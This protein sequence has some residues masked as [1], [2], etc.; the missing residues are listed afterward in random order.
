MSLIRKTA[1]ALIALLVCACAA[2]PRDNRY[3]LPA[4]QTQPQQGAVGELQRRARDALA[5]REYPRAIDYLQRAI[6]IEPRNPHS[7]HYLARVYR[8]S[9]DF[10]RCIEM[11]E[12]SFSY[13]SG[14]DDLDRANRQLKASCRQ[15][16]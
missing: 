16:Y 2:P 6:R 12:R 14:T 7:W 11:I 4:T 13:S 1:C 15:G 8:D 9:G 10:E 5:R 3:Q